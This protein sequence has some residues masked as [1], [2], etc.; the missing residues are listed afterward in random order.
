MGKMN[1]DILHNRKGTDCVK[2]DHKDFVDSRVSDSALPLWLSDME[3]KVADEIIDGKYVSTSSQTGTYSAFNQKMPLRYR[4]IHTEDREKAFIEMLKE[5]FINGKGYTE[6]AIKTTDGKEINAQRLKYNFKF[7][8]LDKHFR[9]LIKSSEH[10]AQ[11]FQNL[12]NLDRHEISS[13][14]MTKSWRTSKLRVDLGN[15]TAYKKDWS[16]VKAVWQ[17][18]MFVHI[19]FDNRKFGRTLQ[20]CVFQTILDGRAQK[21]LCKCFKR[22]QRTCQPEHKNFGQNPA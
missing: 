16:L 10:N 4:F 15:E 1:L 20:K 12:G 13:A 8:E 11:Q 3:F 7:G 18:T 5:H 2:W 9:G 19:S 6:I 22:K 21:P 14:I 17:K